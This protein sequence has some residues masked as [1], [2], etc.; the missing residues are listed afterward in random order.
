MYS[1]YLVCAVNVHHIQPIQYELVQN[2]KVFNVHPEAALLLN[3]RKFKRHEE[4]SQIKM[5]NPKL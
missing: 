2:C 1:A 3:Q 5:L 4:I